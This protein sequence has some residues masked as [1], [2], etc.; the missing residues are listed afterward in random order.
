MKCKIC[1]EKFPSHLI[2]PL[3]VNGYSIIGCPLCLLKK[4]NEI[5]GLPKDTPFRGE[6]ANRLWEEADKI[7]KRRS[8]E[9]TAEL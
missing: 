6:Q 3:F 4:V 2:Q 5:H 9:N 8:H 1:N 7:R